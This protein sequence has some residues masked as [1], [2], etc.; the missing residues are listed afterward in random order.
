MEVIKEVF[1]KCKAK[2]RVALITYVT[3]GYPTV[4]ETPDIMTSMQAGGADIIELGIPFA[5]HPMTESPTIQQANSKTLENG[6]QLSHILQM[7]K[8]ARKQ[9]LAVPV[10]LVGYYN[11]VREYPY[12]EDKL[13]RDCKAAGVDGLIIVDLPLE[14]AVRFRDLCKSKGSTIVHTPRCS[15]YSE[16]SMGVSGTHEKPYGC[17]G[18][19]LHRVHDFT[20][21]SVSVAV[22]SGINT[23]QDFI[24]IARVAEGVVI[25]CPII[26]LL[27]NPAP[28]TGARKVK[29]YCLRVAGRTE[30]QIVIPERR[31][32]ANQPISSTTVYL[33]HDGA[34]DT[35][36]DT[37]VATGL[38]DLETSFEIFS[39]Q[40][41]P[42]S[43]KEGLAELENG[44][45]A[46]NADPDFWAEVNSYAAY[47]NR[48]SP[49]HL[50]PRL[51]AYAGGARIWLKREDMNHT[52]SHKINNVL[53]QIILARRL[54]KTSI[55][56]ET[57]VGQ[58][59]VAT[60]TLCAQFGM[61]CT[62]FMGS[63]DFEREALTVMH[64]RILGAVVVPVDAEHSG[65]K[66]TVRDAINEAFRVW[67]TELQTTHFI[68]GSAFGPHPYPNIVR[69]FQTIIG[70]ETRAQFGAINDG[71]LPDAVVACVGGGS[72]AVGLFYPFLD[73]SSVALVG[74][75]GRGGCM[76]GPS[77]ESIG[78]VHG[79]PTDLSWNEDGENGKT[80]FVSAGLDYPG[81]G[82][83][84]AGWKESGRATIAST[85]D[86]EVLMAFSQLSQLEGVIPALESSHAVAAAVRSAKELGP[87]HDV[88]VC[89][90]GR[91]DKDAETV[92]HIM[93]T[94][95]VD[96]V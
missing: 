26:Y 72:N 70:M 54:G 33:S 39:G 66:G 96:D 42:G 60:A 31:K 86:A 63:E 93:S 41:I 90:S 56:A 40:Y 28:G 35:P 47:T 12:G 74:V 30:H 94:L 45:Q 88:V 36:E 48:P 17:A 27:G 7:V 4:S 38:G 91:G 19:L 65:G 71:R 29:E 76:A 2:N 49:L 50:A 95:R 61:K 37:D 32:Q 89:V 52:G 43:L 11:P 81:I 46:A 8:S 3:A 5:D 23:R 92:A 59:G 68:I 85:T 82:P 58:H 83:E 25:G 18:D 57:G 15:V 1:A 20:G 78:I 64:I 75:Q 55:I 44:F 69:T 34:G 16:C 9:G 10:L 14:D 67:E 6:V 13:L 24:D 51:S 22:G 79:L 80:H 84:L 87:G 73:D 62:I 53:G 77:D 21:N